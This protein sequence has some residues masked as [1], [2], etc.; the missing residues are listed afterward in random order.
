MALDAAVEQAVGVG[1]LGVQSWQE[2]G[3][4]IERGG[5]QREDGSGH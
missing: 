5:K 4:C 2:L 1:L 3:A